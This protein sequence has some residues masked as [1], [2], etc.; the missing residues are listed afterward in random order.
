MLLNDCI[1]IRLKIIDPS[2]RIDKLQATN[3]FIINSDYRKSN[4][5]PASS[6]LAEQFVRYRHFV[7]DHIPNKLAPP[8]DHVYTNV[9]AR[10]RTNM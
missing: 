3:V 7:F 4:N 2:F 8:D 5:K 9:R 10:V 1:N 6:L